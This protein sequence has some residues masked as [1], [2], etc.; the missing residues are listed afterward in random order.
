LSECGA[1]YECKIVRFQHEIRMFKSQLIL[2]L[3]NA[4]RAKK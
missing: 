4:W 1:Y 3:E 2:N